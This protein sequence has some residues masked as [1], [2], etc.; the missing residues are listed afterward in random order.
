M[1]F[2]A[3]RDALVNA[4]RRNFA[5]D[6]FIDALGTLPGGRTYETTEEVWE[7]LGGRGEGQEP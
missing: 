6:R 4:A 1:A 5:D 3:D 2:P 7:A